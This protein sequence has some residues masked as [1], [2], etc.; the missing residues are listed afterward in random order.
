VVD[1]EEIIHVLVG[2]I[3]KDQQLEVIGVTSGEEALKSYQDAN[4]AI[5]AVSLDMSLAGMYILSTFQKIRDLYLQVKVISSSGDPHQ[6]AVRDVMA[7]GARAC[8]P[9]PSVPLTR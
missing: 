5:K 9:T 8:R 2:Q 6:Q 4:G 1:D 7:G 3:P